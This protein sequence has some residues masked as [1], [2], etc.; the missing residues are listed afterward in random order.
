ME[1]T[2]APEAPE[3]DKLTLVA[4]QT[5]A[6]GEFIE[7]L[8]TQGVQLM[9]YRD[10]LTDSR[11]TDPVCRSRSGTDRKAAISCKPARSS[12]VGYAD[13]YD[14]H[15]LH[16]HDPERETAGEEKQG[17][18]C[19]CGQGTYYEVTGIRSW[20][21]EQ[22]GMQQ[23]LADWAGIDQGKLEAEKRAMLTAIRAKQGTS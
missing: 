5:Q 21:H 1:T 13:Y 18:C 4:A 7:W 15:C 17:T 8:E 3:H 14:T 9:R 10:D 20:V 6:I 22:R 23:L 2:T 16:W 11:P 12:D 19:W